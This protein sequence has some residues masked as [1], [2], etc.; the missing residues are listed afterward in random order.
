MAKIPVKNSSSSPAKPS[1]DTIYIDVDDEIT[2]VIDKVDASKHKIVA[3]VLPKRASTFQS[4]VNMRLLKRS[5][6]NAGKNVVLIT[7]ESALLPLAGA[8]EIH[9]AKNLQ[10]KPEIPSAPS[11]LPVTGPDEEELDS[12]EVSDKLDYNKPI[13]E[14]AGKDEESIDLDNDD[15]SAVAAGSGFAAKKASK[16]KGLKIPNFDR[17]RMLLIFGGVGL[18]ALIVFII[19]AIFV[20][21]KA[22]VTISTKSTPVIADFTLAANDDASKY[23]EAEK[24]IPSEL[25]KSDQTDS[26]Q[27]KASGQK[28]LGNKAT[29]SV[30]MTVQ[31]C[32]P[33]IGLPSD[34]PA[35]TGVSTGGKTF[36]TESKASFS[37]NGGSGSCVNYKSGDVNITAQ[38]GGADYNVS[39]AT[40]SVAG[41]SDA[42]GT[43][44]TSGG[45]DKNVTIVTQGD[46]DGAKS[47]ITTEESDEFSKQFQQDLEDDSLYV[48]GSTFKIS[49]PQLSADPA[50]GQEAE[51]SVV[52][53]KITYSVLVV[54]KS[55]LELAVKHAL[56]GQ[57][58]EQKQELSD[59]DVLSN[60]S[61]NVQNQ[62]GG[63][64]TLEIRKETTAIPI[65]DHDA[66]KEMAKGKKPSEIRTSLENYPGVENVDI[67]LS[68]IWVNK[69]PKKTGKIKIVVE[70]IKQD[71]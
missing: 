17:F 66:I 9:V 70:Q 58:D 20:L 16:K 54:K 53:V 68:P 40:F 65:F 2:A 34:V 30:A 11:K 39:S 33:N 21:P 52:Q 67:K 36:I 44:T 18:V 22:T 27:V 59:E 29:G 8:A 12:D 37:L 7:N 49:E 24:L 43:G 35:G 69:A 48:L 51:S 56:K 45:T 57:F 63:N 10:S 6:E 14:L 28:N 60:L 5:A 47:K 13:G 23:S 19:F 1:K 4:I 3:L 50:V 32:A 62:K 46:I 55:D 31:K 25:K 26:T 41:R 64:A 15:T 71:Q 42:S 61:I 38:N